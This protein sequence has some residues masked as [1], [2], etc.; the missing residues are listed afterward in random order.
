MRDSL[1]REPR[2]HGD[3]DGERADLLVGEEEVV[4]RDVADVAEARLGRGVLDLDAVPAVGAGVLGVRRRLHDGDEGADA[5]TRPVDRD[6]VDVRDLDLAEVAVED[7]PV[8]RVERDGIEG[9]GVGEGLR[10]GKLLEGDLLE[11]AVVDL[12]GAAVPVVPVVL[13][14]PVGVLG[15]GVLVVGVH[16]DGGWGN[17]KSPAAEAARLVGAERWGTTVLLILSVGDSPRIPLPASSLPTSYRPAAVAGCRGDPLTPRSGV[18]SDRA[19]A[20]N[21]EAENEE[22]RY[23][24][25]HRPRNPIPHRPC[26]SGA[27]RDA[28]PRPR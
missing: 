17:G 20:P 25:P 26:R 13:V 10:V 22:G 27:P 3:L 9:D 24:R 14:V 28:G 15:V 4:L 2:A 19:G 12:G 7:G 16:G 18:R 5:G 1:E 23:S 6:P 11:E 8:G 21:A